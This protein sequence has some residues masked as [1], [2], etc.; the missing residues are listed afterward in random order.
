[1]RKEA[2]HI[3]KNLELLP[4]DTLVVAQEHPSLFEEGDALNAPSKVRR[5]TLARRSYEINDD[6]LRNLSAPDYID[7]RIVP[8]ERLFERRAPNLNHAL[9][10]C[11]M[12]VFAATTLSTALG[13][14]NL[15]E[16]IPVMMAV[17]PL[18]P[19]TPLEPVPG[20]TRAGAGRRFLLCHH[21]LPADRHPPPAHHRR[22]CLHPPAYDLVARCAACLS[23][24]CKPNQT[25]P[26][27]KTAAAAGG[28]QQRFALLVRRGNA[29][30]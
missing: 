18:P 25:T 24:R 30:G 7:I 13:A 5:E 17:L 26:N 19:L 21:R 3:P 10:V 20:V 22:H 1:M 4:L 29:V 28:P 2:L 23:A 14:F 27:P 12:F 11:Q 16:W 8:Y 6:G 15:S 9:T